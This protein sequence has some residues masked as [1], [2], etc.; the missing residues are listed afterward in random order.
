MEYKFR[1]IE[2]ATYT[3]SGTVS[4]EATNLK[5]AKKKVKN[6]E[7]DHLGDNTID[8]DNETDIKVIGIAQE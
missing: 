3:Q 2:E 4:V 6:R 5:E 1:I 7:Y 8:Y